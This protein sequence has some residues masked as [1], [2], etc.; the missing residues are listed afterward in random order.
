LITPETTTLNSHQPSDG[1]PAANLSLFTKPALIAR[2]IAAGLT[3]KQANANVADAHELTK[4]AHK[5]KQEIADEA[6]AKTNI[7][8]LKEMFGFLAGLHQALDGLFFYNRRRPHSS[9]DGTTPD[10]AYF[11]PL[12]VRVEPNPGRRSTYRRGK[13]VQTTGTT[14]CIDRLSVPMSFGNVRRP[15]ATK[16]PLK[17]WHFR[18]ILS[19]G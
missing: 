5:R 2:K 7:D 10:K 4:A 3:Q 14:S 9:L 11:E 8:E 1:T 18:H 19:G 12:P 6:L 16:P 17:L 15:S 13:S